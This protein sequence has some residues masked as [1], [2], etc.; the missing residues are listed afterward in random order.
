MI[1]PAHW[2]R[3]G[4]DGREQIA[5]PEDVTSIAKGYTGSQQ[6]WGKVTSRPQMNRRDLEYLAW[7]L[8]C[9]VSAVKAAIDQGIV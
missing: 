8:G 5:A 1:A 2:R 7:R 9:S 3:G 4:R 6:F